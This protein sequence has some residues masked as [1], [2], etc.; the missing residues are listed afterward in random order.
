[1]KLNFPQRMQ[2]EQLVHVLREAHRCG[3]D[4][5]L[6]PMGYPPQC[7]KSGRGPVARHWPNERIPRLIDYY[8]GLREETGVGDWSLDIDDVDTAIWFKLKY[9]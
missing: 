4:V 9:L 6:R 5:T 3:A 1:M 8:R 2:C 7:G